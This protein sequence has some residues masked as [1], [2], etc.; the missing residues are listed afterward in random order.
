MPKKDIAIAIVA[1]FCLTSTLFMI[2]PTR[3][4]SGVGEYN[5]WA[6]YNA[7]GIIDIFD[8]VPGAVAFSSEG[9]PTRNVSITNW[10]AE[11]APKTITVCQDYVV[12][13]NDWISLPFLADVEDYD[14]FSIFIT[15]RNTYSETM[16]FGCGPSCQNY[17]ASSG[18]QYLI[19]DLTPSPQW[20]T[21]VVT[22]QLVGAPNMV[23]GV[24]GP[25]GRYV[26]LTIVVYCFN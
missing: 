10:P 11:P 22:G 13:L 24:N 4:Q 15:Y 25:Y 1:T 19:I 21:V 17:N 7:D 14:Y 6:D 26:V 2:T 8:I 16:S 3:S 23:F 12:Q 18:Y 20:K 5:P 9:D